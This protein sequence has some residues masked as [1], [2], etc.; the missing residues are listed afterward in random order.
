[1]K[2]IGGLIERCA[3]MDNLLLAFYKAQ[4]GKQAN[5]EV[6]CFRA[7]L[8]ANL[9]AMGQAVLTGQVQVGKYRTFLIFDPKQRTIC[10]APFAD[11]V[12]HHA[13][14]NVC[15]PHFDSKLIFHTYATRFG[16]GTYAAIDVAHRAMPKYKYVAK[17]DVRKY[18][19]SIDHNVLKNQLKRMFKDRTLLNIFFKIIDSYEVAQDKGLPIGN[20]TS[21]YFA[22]HYLSSFD[23]YVKEKLQIPVYV[24]YMDDMLFW[25][26]DRS[27]VMEWVKKIAEYLGDN[28]LLQLKPPIIVSTSAGVSFLGYRLQGYRIGLNC[29]S[30]NRLR[31]KLDVY[32][33]LLEKKLWSPLE[34]YDHITPLLA[35]A[36]QAYTKRMRR[37]MIFEHQ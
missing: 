16:K 25:G 9:V 13:L 22:N 11:R 24:R 35:F 17:L 2:R 37:N 8:N 12:L 18:F 33:T 19:D 20:L 6:V 10:S 29:R 30:R 26:H 36:E 31:S 21:Q 7:N 5:A 32:E 28:L 23:H 4:R 27:M 14:M 3:D 1:M 34:Y 15:H